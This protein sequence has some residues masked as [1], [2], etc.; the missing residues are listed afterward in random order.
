M[1]FGPDG[2]CCGIPQTLPRNSSFF[3][4]ENKDPGDQLQQI[5]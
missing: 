3:C 1:Y 2:E 5:T 4:R